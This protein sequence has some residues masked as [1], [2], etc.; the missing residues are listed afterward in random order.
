MDVIIL[1]A[2]IFVDFLASPTF[3]H[4]VVQHLFLLNLKCMAI[5][6]FKKEKKKGLH[7]FLFQR[8][9]T[10]KHWL[11]LRPRTD[12]CLNDYGVECVARQ[13]STPSWCRADISLCAR[14]APGPWR[15]VRCARTPSGPRL[16]LILSDPETLTLTIIFILW[17]LK[18]REDF[19]RYCCSFYIDVLPVSLFLVVCID[20][21]TFQSYSFP[22][23]Y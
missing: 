22:T 23:S 6:T 18:D 21:Y 13:P 9:K 5:T 16:E 8:L 3:P 1:M 7:L 14:P 19:L 17:W 4:R 20:F 12:R 2:N 10:V 15:H 11:D